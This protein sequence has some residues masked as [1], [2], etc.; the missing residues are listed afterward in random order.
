MNDYLQSAF[1]LADDL[2]SR[3]TKA[4]DTSA[5]LTGGT[6]GFDPGYSKLTK[7][8]EQYSHYRG[9]LMNTL[10]IISIATSRP[11]PLNRITPTISLAPRVGG[12][13]ILSD[14]PSA[15]KIPNVRPHRN[16]V[17]CVR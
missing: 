1:A 4:P 5:M 7:A 17:A 6:Y 15:I 10:A 12:R 14:D 16:T 9:L 3:A 13:D 11:L 8:K 2:R